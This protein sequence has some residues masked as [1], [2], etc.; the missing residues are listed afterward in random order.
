MG[1]LTGILAFA[2][3]LISPTISKANREERPTIIKIDSD[4]IVVIKN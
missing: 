3:H 2:K 1:I 4:K